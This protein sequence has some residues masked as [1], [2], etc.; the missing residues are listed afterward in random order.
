MPPPTS[1]PSRTGRKPSLAQ[2][3]AAGRR[4]CADQCRGPHHEPDRRGEPQPKPRAGDVLDDDRQVRPRQLV[5]QECHEVDQEDPADGRVADDAAHR[6]VSERQHPTLRHDGWPDLARPEP[7]EQ[8]RDDGQEGR[9][10]EHVRQRPAET[11]DEEPRQ[12]RPDR[13]PDRP[14]APKTAMTNPSRRSGATSGSRQASRR[15]S[16][17]GTRSAAGSTRAAT[18]PATARRRRTR[19]PRRAR[20]GRSPPCANTCRPR[21]PTAARAARRRRR[22]AR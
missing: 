16:R 7:D 2:R 12:Q 20:S 3:P 9:E 22:S 8:R 11:I 15:Y 18:A 19:P 17:A 5:R 21:R 13:E 6:P 4:H 1:A 10:H 14:A